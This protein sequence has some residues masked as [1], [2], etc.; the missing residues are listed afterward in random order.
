MS[1]HIEAEQSSGNVFADLGVPNPEEHLVKADLAI[2]IIKIIRER[3]LKQSQAAKIL[4][5]KQ[6]TISNLTR[7]KLDGFT[8]D[9]LS[10]FLNA[11][12]WDVRI[13]PEKRSNSQSMAH[14]FVDNSRGIVLSGL[15]NTR[16]N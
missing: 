1:N 9:R 16:S 6:P 4:G 5:V 13:T 7:G 14:T 15:F 12:G 8:I 3:G 2:E 10:R 11:L